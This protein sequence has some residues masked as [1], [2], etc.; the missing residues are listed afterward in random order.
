MNKTQIAYNKPIRIGIFIFDISKILMNNFHCKG[1]K[2]N[3][4]DCIKLLFTDPD[5]LCCEIKIKDFYKDIADDVES[6][7]DT[8]DYSKDHSAVGLVGFKVGC[9]KKVTGKFT[10]EAANK[11][12]TEFVGLSAKCYAI[13]VD[14]VDSKKCK[15]TKKT[16]IKKRLTIKDYRE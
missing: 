6:K 16:V 14:G 11:Q 9:N 5:S 4:G 13:T 7:S 12:I 1:R 15:G 10:D 3:Y 2:P 8:N